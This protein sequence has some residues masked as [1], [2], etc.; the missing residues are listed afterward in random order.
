MIRGIVKGEDPGAV[1]AVGRR[2]R[3]E[4]LLNLLRDPCKDLR[5]TPTGNMAIL[6]IED[7]TK[8]FRDV[9]ALDNVSFEFDI[10]ILSILGPSGCGK[11]TLL[12]CITGLKEKGVKS[13]D[14]QS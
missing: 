10:G 13:L 9:K 11:T 3:R 1:E 7:L 2:I 12:R 4:I 14:V 5:G 6:K 8:A